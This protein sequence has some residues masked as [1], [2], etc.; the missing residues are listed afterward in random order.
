MK[1]LF[2]IT[3]FVFGCTLPTLQ[4]QLGFRVGANIAKQTLQSSS[5][6]IP[7]KSKAGLDLGILLNIPVGGAFSIQPEVHFMQKGYKIEDFGMI[8]GTQLNTLNYLEVPVSAKLTFGEQIKMFVQAGPSLGYLMGGESENGSN[9]EKITLTDWDRMDVGGMV[10][11]GFAFAIIGMEAFV[12][13]RYLI[14]FTKTL[15]DTDEG[16]FYNRGL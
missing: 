6:D 1:N 12:D 11:T 3:L 7:F 5:S 14:G 10:G 9:S 4:A 8:N 16:E 13:I 15:K 2:L